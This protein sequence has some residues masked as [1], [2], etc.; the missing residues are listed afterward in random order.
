MDVNLKRKI[1]N[2]TRLF[3]FVSACNNF[4]TVS[5]SRSVRGKGNNIVFARGVLRKKVKI[6]CKGNHNKLTI[7]NKTRLRNTLIEI[8]GSN[9]TIHI[10]ANIVVYENTHFLVEGDNCEIYIGDNVIIGGGHFFAGESNTKIYVGE[11]SMLSRDVKIDTSD[12]HSIIDEATGLRINR[13]DN[14]YIGRHVWIG[15]GVHVF[16]GAHV[17]DNSVIGL[18]SLVNKK[19]EEPNLL[20]AGWPAKIIRQGI[21]WTKE[22]L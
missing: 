3:N 7:A 12:F 16:R 18:K 17:S 20:L 2:N 14:V 15:N 21:N 11:N 5:N 4:F 1:L 6:V 10:G 9:N 8:Y 22:K 13:A 19:Y